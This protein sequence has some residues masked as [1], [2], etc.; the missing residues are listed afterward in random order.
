MNGSWTVFGPNVRN[1]KCGGCT[2]CCTLLPV[3]GMPSGDKPAN[4]RCAH[5]CSRGCAIY[6]HR[7]FSCRTFTCRW[8]MDES[9]AGLRRP[10]KAGYVVDPM[11]DSIIV[12]GEPKDVIQVWIDP[13]RPD[14]HEDPA[15]RAWIESMAAEHGLATLIRW[16]GQDGMLLIAPILT[17]ENKWGE[18]RSTCVDEKEIEP[19]RERLMRE[20]V[21]RG[22]P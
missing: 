14:A 11:L 22:K 3:K 15:L 10:D 4:T 20:M 9:T 2:L 5:V 16:G 17:S 12:N 21:F 8:L 13:K 6:K 19:H 7:P 18:V 1:R